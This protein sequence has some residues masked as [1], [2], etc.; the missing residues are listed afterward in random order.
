MPAKK[1]TLIFPSL[2][3]LWNFAQ[4]IRAS[5]IEIISATSTLT[6]DCND[7]DIKLAKEKYGAIVRDDR[8]VSQN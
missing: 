6:C 7:E 4:A 3:Q 2:P 5:S 1:V 8:T